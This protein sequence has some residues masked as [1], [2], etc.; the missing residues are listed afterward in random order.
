[1]PAV[2]PSLV[3]PAYKTEYRVRNW[4]Q[5]E[6]GPRSRGDVTTWFSEEATA[7][8]IS[9]STGRRG[10][11]RLYSN[12]AIV[13]DT[14]N[15][16]PDRASTDRRL[17]RIAAQYPGLRSTDGS[18]SQHADTTSSVARRPDEAA[19]AR[20]SDSPDR[21]KHR[22]AS[23][24]RRPLNRASSGLFASSERKRATNADLNA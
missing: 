17:R 7:D 20:W 3:H 11:Q 13:A 5:H 24:W 19:P 15:R 22:T 16:V 6:Q 21:R 12:L 10:G 23:P 1:M 9:K 14:A 18:G 8:W 2:K 4:R